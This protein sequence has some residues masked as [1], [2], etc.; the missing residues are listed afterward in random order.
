[1]ADSFPTEK[2]TTTIELLIGNV[3]Y[4]DFILPQTVEVQPGL[5]MLASKL[6]WILTG[7]TTELTADDTTEHSTLIMTYSSN[8]IKDTGLLIPD[9]SFPTKPNLEDFWKLETIG[10]TDYP[11]DT[12][13]ERALQIFDLTMLDT[14]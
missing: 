1:M 14:G 6:G 13:K 9:K 3:Y 2:E 5:Y 4:L 10:I 8:I 7:R 11:L 12:D